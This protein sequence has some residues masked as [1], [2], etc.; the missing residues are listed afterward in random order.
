MPNVLSTKFAQKSAEYA[1]R[2]PCF[3]PSKEMFFLGCTTNLLKK[4]KTSS[5]VDTSLL[6]NDTRHPADDGQPTDRH[7]EQ[8]LCGRGNSRQTK[9]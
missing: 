9:S 3:F 5:Q 6:Y 1:Q 2:H 7:R 4:T 8:R